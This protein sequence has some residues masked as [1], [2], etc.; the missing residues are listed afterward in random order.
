M[1]RLRAEPP[2]TL[3]GRAVEQAEDLARG[4]RRRCRRPTAC[5]TGSPTA[6]G[7]SSVPPAPS[8]SS[9]RYLEVVVPV[10]DGDV[11]AAR[12]TAAADLAAIKRD[13]AAALDLG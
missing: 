6:A 13:V 11:A 10:A 5:A 7:S 12:R 3:G 2:T 9:R 8:P 4:H 1:A